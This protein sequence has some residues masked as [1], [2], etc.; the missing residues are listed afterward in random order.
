MRTVT[1]DFTTVKKMTAIDWCPHSVKYTTISGHIAKKGHLCVHMDAEE[2][3]HKLATVTNIS[4]KFTNKSKN[5]HVN[6]VTKSL[7][8]SIIGRRMKNLSCQNKQKENL[9]NF[10]NSNN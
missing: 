8:K 7:L 9:N 2:V 6:F 1:I 5:I 3:S 10:K 4:N